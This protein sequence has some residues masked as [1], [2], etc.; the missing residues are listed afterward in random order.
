MMLRRR[1]CRGKV[2]RVTGDWHMIWKLACAFFKNDDLE[3][4]G[5]VSLCFLGHG[6]PLEGLGPC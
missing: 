3:D 4:V 1:V 2:M 5:W 6:P